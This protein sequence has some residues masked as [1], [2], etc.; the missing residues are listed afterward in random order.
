LPAT[1]RRA[2]FKDQLLASIATYSF[3]MLTSNSL[4]DR[5]FWLMII[6]ARVHY[7]LAETTA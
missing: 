1:A 5:S 7:S 2:D 6:F 4:L 3:L